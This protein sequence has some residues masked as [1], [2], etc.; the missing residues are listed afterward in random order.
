MYILNEGNIS[1]DFERKKKKTNY[2]INKKN[3]IT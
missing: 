2:T 1:C 3:V